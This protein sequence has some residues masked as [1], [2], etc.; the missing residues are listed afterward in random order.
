[1][2]DEIRKVK[3]KS[4][5]KRGAP[6]CCD[7]QFLFL[8]IPCRVREPHTNH[9]LL[10]W[11]PHNRAALLGGKSPRTEISR[12]MERWSQWENPYKMRIYFDGRAGLPTDCP[13]PIQSGQTTRSP[14]F[15]RRGIWY[16]HPMERSGK[17]WIC[18]NPLTVASSEVAFRRV[19][20]EDRSRIL[21]YWLGIKVACATCQLASKSYN[22]TTIP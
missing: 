18:L 6:V 2:R 21:M 14:R 8:F 22:K 13:Y 1:M 15:K 3:R 12:Q 5:G 10:V 9:D 20:Q 17:P 19:Y 4:G 7:S 11:C 16:R